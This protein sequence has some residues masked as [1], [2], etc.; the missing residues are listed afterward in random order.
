[1]KKVYLFLLDQLSECNESVVCIYASMSLREFIR[2]S[3]KDIQEV[4][5]KKIA[6][7]EKLTQQVQAKVDEEEKTE[8]E[9]PVLIRK[10]SRKNARAET[11]QDITGK[12]R[13]TEKAKKTE[14]KPRQQAIEV[15]AHKEKESRAV[16]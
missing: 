9:M 2:A 3:R 6:T 10:N 5:A 14:H 12:W 8:E 1:M 16:G 15:R 11:E 7:T 13:R 4:A